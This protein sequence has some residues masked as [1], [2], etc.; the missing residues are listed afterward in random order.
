MR[1]A[2]I[3]TDGLIKSAIRMATDVEPWAD[4]VFC[5]VEDF[6]AG[7]GRGEALRIPIPKPL[8]GSVAAFERFTHPLSPERM[9]EMAAEARASIFTL[10]LSPDPYI[11][12]G[13]LLAPEITATAVVKL[14][15]PNARPSPEPPPRRYEL[16]TPLMEAWVHSDGWVSVGEVHFGRMVDG[17]AIRPE[18]ARKLVEVLAR[19]PH[20]GITSKP[21]SVP[22]E[23][24]VRVPD[25]LDLTAYRRAKQLQDYLNHVRAQAETIYG[26][27][28]LLTWV[29]PEPTEP[30]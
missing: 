27:P 9:E 30:K 15:E 1:H 11:E 16:A 14:P 5:N 7:G 18:D 8:A 13:R 20:R 28:P 25:P 17:C 22:G 21:G 24:V 26:P 23:I 6:V 3:G 10:W 4:R 12:R 29:E 2:F 19:A